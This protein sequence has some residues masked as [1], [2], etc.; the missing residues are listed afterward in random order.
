MKKQLKSLL[1][2]MLGKDPEAVVVSYATGPAEQ[3]RRMVEEVRRMIPDRR[4]FLV[5]ADLGIA[6]VTVVRDVELGR[7]RIGMA[8]VYFD[9][10]PV[11]GALR[12]AAF[13]RSPGKILA[14][15]AQM[16]TH[17]LQLRTWL[18][19]LLFW[20][21]V[22]LDRIYLRPAWMGFLTHDRTTVPDDAVVIEGRAARRGHGR[23]G[24]LTPFSPYPL[25]HGGAVRLFA[26][27]REMSK[28]FDVFLFAFREHEKVEDLEPL[29]EFCTSISLVTKPRYR[30]PRWCTL[31]PP[32]VG[33]YESAPMRRLVAGSRKQNHI[34]L[35]QVE[36]TQLARY[37]GDV[38]VEHDVTYDLYR[39]LYEKE[40]TLSSWW[41]WWRWKRF[42]KAAIGRFRRI[43]AMSDKDA[44]MLGVTHTRVIPN[45]VDLTRFRPTSER[46]GCRL[47]FIGSF[48]HF[49]NVMA[50]RFVMEQVW[51]RLREVMPEITMTVVTGPDP[52]LFYPAARS[53]TGVELKA[54]VAD[55]RPLYEEANIVLV[56][57]LVSAGTNVKVLEAMAME[58]AIVSTT[59]GCG[60]IP[61]SNGEHVLIADGADAFRDAILRLAS[62][63]ALRRRLAVQARALVEEHFDWGKL[64]AMQRELLAEILPDPITVRVGTLAD[65][66]RV[67]EIQLEALPGSRWDPDNYLQHEFYVGVYDGEIAGFLVARQTAPDER[68]ILNVAVLESFRRLGIGERMLRRLLQNGP[69]GEVF[70][71]VRLSNHEA[72]RVYERTGFQYAGIRKNYYEEPNEDAVI[73]KIQVGGD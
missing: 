43:V 1:F 47:L 46:H 23:I 10:D 51:P 70:L 11:Y 60:G 27:L 66:A 57:T 4:H 30:Q 39:Q 29:R 33:E 21:G 63:Y 67:R 53:E 19:S 56:P 13:L 25:S 15:N 44:A 32:E 61:V 20:R 2:R 37:A 49:P 22:P 48:R 26:L 38:L 34:D 28:E 52:H 59:S 3:V 7:Y 6:G 9:G 55:V 64:G 41:D 31:L 14:F 42:E 71:E 62:D 68:E 69:A 5:G 50:Y 24:V 12:R 16:E 8:A 35:F 72:Q 54:F 73:M 36:F 17:H 58:R 18:A 45:G 40:R 65:V